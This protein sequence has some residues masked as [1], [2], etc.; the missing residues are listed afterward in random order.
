MKKAFVF[1]MAICLFSPFE[2]FA[3][4]PKKAKVTDKVV[5]GL[6]IRKSPTT[7]SAELALLKAGDIID[8]QAV[9]GKWYKTTHNGVT[10]WVSSSGGYLEVTEYGDGDGNEESDNDKTKIPRLRKSVKKM[11]VR[12]LKPEEKVYKGRKINISATSENN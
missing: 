3:E 1:L 9:S 10:G 6:R 11:K 2:L 4:V 5:V 12:S 7:K 8:I